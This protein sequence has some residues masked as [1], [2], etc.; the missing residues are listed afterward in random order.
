ME[1]TPRI[2]QSPLAGAELLG[3]RYRLGERLGAGGMATIFRARDEALERDVAVKVLHAHLVDDE[4]LR[5][6]F[7]TE[8]RHAASLLHPNI[9]NVFD[10]GFDESLGGLPYI[11][12]EHV[13]GPSLREV[14]S[15]R[16]RLTPGEALAVLE[17]V[18]R[19]LVRAHGLGVVHR[20]VKPENIL[21]APDGSPKI[22]DFGIARAVAETGHTQ[23]G[24]LIGSIHYIA[25]E[26]VDG[27]EATG[28]TDQ[29]AL[30]VMAFELVTGRKP[31]PGE[32]PMVIA[33]RHAQE[34]IP[35]PGDFVSDCSSA[36][37]K[38][39]TRATHP[40][41]TRRY[42]DLS[43]FAA[44]LIEA[45]P[46]GAQPIELE[47]LA[48][49]EDRTVVIPAAGTETIT[50]NRG[51][52]R[53]AGQRP[54]TSRRRRASRRSRRAGRARAG[55]G[56]GTPSTAEAGSAGSPAE[57]P[58]E[59]SPAE[60]PAPA[61]RRRGRRRGPRRAMV[62]LL[63][64]ALVGTG[65]FVVWNYAVAPVTT[66]PALA[67]LPEADA[68]AQLESHG[69]DMVVDERR[70]DFEAAEGT[71]LEQKPP[72]GAELRRG[73][74]VG[75]VVSAGPAEVTMPEVVGTAEDE[76]LQRLESDDYRFVVNRDY[77]HSPT[78]DAG[79][80][81]AQAPTPGTELRQGDTVIINV[82][83]GVE[84]VTVPDL[85]GMDRDEALEALEDA[86]LQGELAFAYSDAVPNEGQVV[87]QSVDSGVEVDKHSTVTVTISQGPATI[88]VPDVE[89]D[90]VSEAVEKLEDAGFATRVIEEPRP[91]LGPFRRGE[92]GQV[93]AQDPQPGNSA[94]RGSQVDLYTFSEAAEDGG[95]E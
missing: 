35:P 3:G 11:V 52:V 36:F 32:S 22:A 50:M 1:T 9:V 30:G 24:A 72:E 89:G 83:L 88:E 75:V 86:D 12:M 92:T 23:T 21:I 16:G 76:A 46:G 8:A 60:T 25:P 4:T 84:Q 43:E 67:D 7:R 77:E 74:T 59:G 62:V 17:P 5:Q 49:H 65:A 64:L 10:Q 71:V 58:S 38:A 82:S 48:G 85:S 2:G 33:A 39:I 73:G 15:E 80:V 6:R 51:G 81:Q 90:E 47:G 95:E 27:K 41:P 20:D 34:R 56:R 26:L 78:T 55:A 13:D 94:Q 28:A 29:Y 45:V 91:Q 19:G 18:C 40:D 44:A 70:Y 63:L 31:L 14:L 66:V 93:E 61:P 79:V 69:L 57:P 54:A 42:A 87:T 37:D 68:A 53:S